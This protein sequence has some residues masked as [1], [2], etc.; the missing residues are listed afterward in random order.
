M[1]NDVGGR[2]FIL[3]MMA[4]F[5]ATALCWSEHIHEGVYSAIVVAILGAYITGNVVEKIGIAKS[6]IV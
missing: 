2:K 4:L 6:N 5:L 3:A 1:I